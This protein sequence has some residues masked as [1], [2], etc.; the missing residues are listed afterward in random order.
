[1]HQ[2]AV[3]ETV[4]VMWHLVLFAKW[5]L[6]SVPQGAW[7][8]FIKEL[9]NKKRHRVL[10][11]NGIT[12]SGEIFQMGYFIVSCTDIHA[13]LA[14]SKEQHWYIYIAQNEIFIN[15]PSNQISYV[16]KGAYII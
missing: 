16:V 2:H 13:H 4:K 12:L 9:T 7:G 10:N 5:N 14:T 1:M 3:K 8:Q 6:L 11:I 15:D